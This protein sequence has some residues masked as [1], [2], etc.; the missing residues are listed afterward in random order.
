MNETFWDAQNLEIEACANF[1]DFPDPENCRP[2]FFFVD[3]MLWV[4]LLPKSRSD[5]LAVGIH[6]N[7]PERPIPVSSAINES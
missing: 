1:D 7:Y 2:G 3:W 6:R 4:R 5:V